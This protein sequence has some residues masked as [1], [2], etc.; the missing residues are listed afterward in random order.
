MLAGR[1]SRD[2]LALALLAGLPLLASLWGT[3]RVSAVT[4]KLGPGDSPYIAGF[5]PEYEIDEG[6]ATQWANQD[7]AIELPLTVSGGP[8]TLVYRFSRPVA[9]EGDAAV[10]SFGGAIVDR[11]T[12]RTGIDERRADMGALPATPFNVGFEVVSRNPRPLGL[13]LD[14]VRL[15]AGSGA[16]VRLRGPTL[17]RPALLPVLLYLVLR[18]A[19]WGVRGAAL[20][21]APWSAAATLGLALD[22]WL[23]HRLLTGLPESLGILGLGGVASAA[24][25]RAR[26][27]L[28]AET[29]RVVTALGATAFLFRAAAFNHP[30]YYYSDLRIHAKLAEMVRDAGWDFLLSPT[31]HIVRHKAWSRVIHG[32]VYAFPYTPAF[33][34]PF[35]L[36][37][38]PSDR[39]ITVLKLG[40]AA[41]TVGPIL[42]L[43]SLC[44]RWRA[45]TAGVFL[46]LLV[47]IYVHHLGLA[48]LAALFGHAVDMA[49]LAWLAGRVDRITVP[50]TFLAASALT[51]ACQLSYVGSVIVLPVFL[52]TLAAFVL[53]EHRSIAGL[54]R[55]LA[56]LGFGFAGS[57]LAVI[58]YYRHF[59]PL[60][61]DVL[62]HAASGTPV[63]AADDAPKQGFF[64]VVLR[65][66]RRYFDGLWAPL[67]LWGFVLLLRRGAGGPVIAAWG[68]TYLL[69]LLGRAKLPFVFQHPHDALFV[70]PL[71]CL[72]A[73]EALSTVAR[74]GGWRQGLAAVLLAVLIL[75]SLL[76]QWQAWARHFQPGL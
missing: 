75:H 3:G 22:P 59:S 74:A 73:G 45:S 65:F 62:S 53:L 52:A 61:V 54:R 68:A 28:D 35:A 24:A 19:G 18:L 5:L 32:K 46:L 71:V 17:L 76:L 26:G 69:L 51:A 7:A 25:L 57:L 4:L 15:E 66:T 43:W 42:A 27:R 58:L 44:R 1:T 36:T 72:A 64:E 2:L 20:L 10:V 49:F 67:A 9:E 11:F 23:V 41:A 13:R 55:A 21:S 39:L 50:A 40:A 37:T 56:I 12:P 38:L 47:P 63:V 31:E 6:N 34:A 30:D 48:Y 33:H 60:V 16:R 8:L 29:V 14:W 70:T